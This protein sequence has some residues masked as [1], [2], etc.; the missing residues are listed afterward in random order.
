MINKFQHNDGGREAAGFK[1]EAGDCVARSIAIAAEL[2]YQQVYDRLA[3]GNQSQRRSKHTRAH[4]GKRTARSG[5][6]THR[7]WFKDYM[8][9][10]GFEWVPTMFV[11]QG[12][13]VHLRSDE[14]PKGRIITVLSRHY[15]AVVDGVVQDTWPC[16]RNGTRCVYGYWRKGGDAK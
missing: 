16:D 14:L 6:S 8:R 7:K 4:H 12:C 5:I 15:A 2:P 10:L 3:A 9:K 11:G 13:K 1:G